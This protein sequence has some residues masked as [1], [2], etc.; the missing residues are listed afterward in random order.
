M[1]FRDSPSIRRAPILAALV[2]ATAVFATPTEAHAEDVSPTA[3]GIV[4]G[5]FLGAEAV[6]FGEALFGIRSTWAYLIGTGAGAAGGAVAGYMIEKSAADGQVPAYMLA[7]GLVLLIPAIVVGLDQTRYLPTEG[8][9]ED[10]PVPSD[11]GKP[12]GSAVVGAEAAP[13]P[14]AVPA[15]A[16]GSESPAPA[17]PGAAPAPVSPPPAGGGG[18]PRVPQSALF[19][20]DQGTLSV[21]MPLPEVR[22]LLGA[23][24]RARLGAEARG[25]EIRFPFVRVTF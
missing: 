19:R 21:G 2:A 1:P 22:P 20:L 17:A 11:P 7:G 13:S 12:G 10:K 24:D 25:S 4:G 16:S 3:K 18:A 8:A 14:T 23:A 9:R 6:V 5:A 15:P